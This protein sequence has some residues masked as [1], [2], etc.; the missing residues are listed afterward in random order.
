MTM[1]TTPM[2]CCPACNGTTRQPVP[3]SSQR[4]IKHNARWGHWGIAG[5]QPAGPGPFAD[6][7]GY[8]GGTLPCGNCGG[9]HMAMKA[10]GK[11]RLRPDGTPCLHEYKTDEFRSNKIR[12]YHVSDCVHC[13]D[14]KV[15]DSGD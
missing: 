2:G 14:H 11:V 7:S 12:G 15:I 3:E 13:G 10:T 6:G 5:Y 4:Y 8:E 1:T 9:Q